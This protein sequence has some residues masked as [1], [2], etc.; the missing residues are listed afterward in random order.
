MGARSRL[1]RSR[2]PGGDSTS[3]AS[4]E[5]LAR[6]SPAC[7]H[8]AR[9][10]RASDM[11]DLRYHVASLAAVFLALLIG[12][13]VGVGLSG[14]VDEK[15][16]DLLRERINALESRLESAGE[17]RANLEEVLGDAGA[18][19]PLRMRALKIPIDEKRIDGAL[20]GHAELEQYRGSNAL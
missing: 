14:R 16:S 9:L 4:G 5:R 15:E 6:R 20:D 13:L 19:T 11:F 18:R 12:I 17:G 2:P 1:S 3:R 10:P 8:S 7:T